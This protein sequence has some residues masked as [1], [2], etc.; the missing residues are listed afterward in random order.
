VLTHI[1][2][3]SGCA[4]GNFAAGGTPESVGVDPSGRFVYVANSADPSVAGYTIDPSTGVLTHISCT[5]ACTLGNFA[6]GGAPQSVSVDPSGKFVYVANSADDSIS[7]Y[8]IDDA[9]GALTPIDAS[10]LPGT[11]NFPTGASPTSITTDL[12]GQF[13]YVSNSNASTVS[14]YAID[15]TTGALVPIDANP[16]ISGVNNFPAGLTPTEI[17]TTGTRQ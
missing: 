9:T 3:A 11:Q 17:V 4:L 14:A 13:A 15:A 5:S 8:A 16:N 10:G 1:S 2:C 6:A 12:S 7:A